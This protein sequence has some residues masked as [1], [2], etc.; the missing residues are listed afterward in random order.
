[1]MLQFDGR[2]HPHTTT[3]QRMRADAWPVYPPPM[4]PCYYYHPQQNMMMMMV[5]QPPAPVMNPIP[6]YRPHP[7]RRMNKDDDD[8][9]LAVLQHQMRSTPPPPPPPPSNRRQNSAPVLHPP[10]KPV[11][12][13]TR[14]QTAPTLRPRPMSPQQQQQQQQQLLRPINNAQQRSLSPPPQ[15]SP[16]QYKRPAGNAQVPQRK[17]SVASHPPNALRS[18]PRRWPSSGSAPNNGSLVRSASLPTNTHADPEPPSPTKKD[19]NIVTKAKRWFSLNRR[20][21]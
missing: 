20:Q 9:P 19:T 10:L 4:Y 11:R 2:S 14:Q 17:N 13:A 6:E 3:K 15:R 5:P 12:P 8:T 18:A 1:M 21:R 7:R 16:R